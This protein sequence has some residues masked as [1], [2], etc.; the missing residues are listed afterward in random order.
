MVQEYIPGKQR[1]N[2]HLVLD[3]KGELK[4]GFYARTLRDFLRITSFATATESLG[5][6]P[7]ALQGGKLMQE[8]RWWGG[9]TVQ[10]KIDLR[11][12]LPKLMEI[13]PRLGIRLWHRTELGIND[14]LMC[15]NIAQGKKVEA[16]KDYPSETILL[17]PIEEIVGLDYTIFWRATGEFP[18]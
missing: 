5:F 7:Y 15:L 11:D 8:L 13:N 4:V 9:A 12:G 14:P 1:T 18:N 3:K 17:E 10:A 16:V 6:H 2:L